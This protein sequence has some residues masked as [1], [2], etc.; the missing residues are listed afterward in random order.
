MNLV[1][2]FICI[3]LMLSRVEDRKVVLGLFNAAYEFL[4]NSTES[5]FPR[6][7]QMIMDYENPI[8]K[9]S[10]DLGPLNRVSQ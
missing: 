3:M 2:N 9:L 5:A 4:H 6:L 8:K 7:G 10:E 1:V